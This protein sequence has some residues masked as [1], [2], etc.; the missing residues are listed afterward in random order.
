[1]TKAPYARSFCT[2]FTGHESGVSSVKKWE[3][4]TFSEAAR[5]PLSGERWR[6]LELSRLQRLINFLPALSYHQYG[7]MPAGEA[8]AVIFAA[9]TLA[10][11]LDSQ[12][13]SGAEKEKTISSFLCC[14]FCTNTWTSLTKRFGSGSWGRRCACDQLHFYKCVTGTE[15]AAVGDTFDMN[16][17]YSV[18]INVFNEKKTNLCKHF[19]SSKY[20]FCKN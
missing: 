5:R 3:T 15:Q 18:S 11:T 14:F 19:L 20:I 9:E 17:M 1:M 6:L 7:G 16:C 10:E 8:T 4:N 12:D 2:G 13:K